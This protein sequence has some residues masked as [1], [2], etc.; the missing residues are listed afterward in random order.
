MNKQIA[1]PIIILLLV[2]LNSLSL[3]F[4]A[5]KYRGNKIFRTTFN[6]VS[7]FDK[8]WNEDL[9]DKIVLFGDSRVAGW[10]PGLD[11]KG[12]TIINHGINGETTEQMM[13]R[14]EKHVLNINP[15]IVIIQAGIN[16]LVAA[17]MAKTSQK[18]IIYNQ[19][20]QNLTHMLTKLSD[21]NIPVIFLSVIEP[22]RL[23]PIRYLLWGNDLTQLVRQ[24][25]NEILS[26][27][28]TNKV[29]FLEA[30]TILKEDG[31]WKP[32]VNSDAL[33]FKEAAYQLLNNEIKKIIANQLTR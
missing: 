20:L 12:L 9:S 21:R 13:L 17:S 31:Q 3:Y 15:K 1:M 26:G 11:V 19:C 16:D 29:Y 23:D 8:A 10:K 30:N 4:V 28:D 33:H 7:R 25:N 32:N 22:Y 18:K 14:F 24:L 6:N 27:I 5:N 2:I